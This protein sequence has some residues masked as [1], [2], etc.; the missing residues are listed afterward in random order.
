MTTI[1]RRISALIGLALAAASCGAN[2]GILNSGRPEPVPSASLAKLSPLEK[3]LAAMR[4]A[5]FDD[6][7]VLSR[8]DGGT[9]TADDRKYVKGLTSDTNRRVLTEDEKYIVIGT[10]TALPKQA[11][12]KLQARFA[13][14]NYPKAKPQNTTGDAISDK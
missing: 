12:D 13:L 3:E 9:F 6:V 7:Y 11:L 14:Q 4:T 1:M 5:D 10:N 2:Q 8:T